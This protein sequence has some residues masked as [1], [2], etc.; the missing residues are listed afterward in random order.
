MK[1][2]LKLSL[3]FGVLAMV[4]AGCSRDGEGVVVG[5][6]EVANAPKPKIT[7]VGITVE[8]LSVKRIYD[9]ESEWAVI[10]Y[11]VTGKRQAGT[12]TTHPYI[13]YGLNGADGRLA[14]WY[15][16]L[17]DP[18]QEPNGYYTATMRVGGLVG[19]ILDYSTLR[20]AIGTIATSF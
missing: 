6:G 16:D 14:F 5:D 4:F 3:I 18:A 12:E 13:L 11:K 7:A 9:G 2:I 15:A 1:N 10:E 20:A 19:T 17:K 8:T